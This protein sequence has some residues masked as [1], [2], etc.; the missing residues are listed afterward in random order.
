MVLTVDTLQ[1]PRIYHEA[2][3][4][5]IGDYGDSSYR[6]NA[7][8]MALSLPTSEGPQNRGLTYNKEMTTENP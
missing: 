3:K 2:F 6:E 1:I 4:G 5:L 8:L 7:R